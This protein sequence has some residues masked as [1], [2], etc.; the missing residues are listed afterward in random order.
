MLGKFQDTAV[1]Y[2]ALAEFA[3]R[4]RILHMTNIDVSVE[5]MATE[6]TKHRVHIANISTSS[7]NLKVTSESFH[8]FKLC[9]I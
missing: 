1:A 2:R 9:S 4:S 6:M 7:Y 8:F 3:L 5:M